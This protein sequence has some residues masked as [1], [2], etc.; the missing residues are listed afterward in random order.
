MSTPAIGLEGLEFMTGLGRRALR[1]GKNLSTFL[2][3]SLLIVLLLAGG[4]SRA[5]VVG[6]II[7][8]AASWSVILLI[9]AS[10]RVLTPWPKSDLGRIMAAVVAITAIQLVPLPPGLWQA[11]PGRSIFIEAAAVSGQVQP[12]RPVSISPGRTFNAL[13]SLVVAVAMMMAFNSLGQRAL[14]I[15]LLAIVGA[16]VLSA[17]W[18]A[19]QFSGAG[20]GNPFVNDVTGM[21]S[22]PFANRNHLAAF[23]AIGC[24]VCPA[25]V[26]F[27]G[28]GRVWWIGALA[29]SLFFLL[30]LIATGSRAGILLA[31]VACIAAVSIS[32]GSLRTALSNPSPRLKFAAF[33]CFLVIAMLLI[34]ISIRFGRAVAIDRLG[35][36]DAGEDLR[37]RALPTVWEMTVN[38][39]PLGIGFG[40]FD[41]AFRIWEPTSL[42]QLPYFNQAHNDVLQVVLEGGVLSAAVGIAAIVWAAR[43]YCRAIRSATLENRVLAHTAASTLLIIVLASLLDYPGRTPLIM[44]TTVI[45]ALWL[46]RAGS[47]KAA[48]VGDGAN[49]SGNSRPEQGRR[50]IRTCG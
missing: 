3:L 29:V 26:A 42:L 50:E 32:W 48:R 14:R 33:A 17:L 10:D 36:L 18:G 31:A 25:S 28:G 13:G 12:W 5:D 30:V 27:V 41:P 47:P 44:A 7:V 49:A 38:Y 34:F 9:L 24:V 22:G 15:S 4:A 20:F 40:A 21:V 37:L 43:T 46:E 8:R 23:L 16:I 19:L 35:S 39:F 11:L 45:A 1:P 6:Q 2:F